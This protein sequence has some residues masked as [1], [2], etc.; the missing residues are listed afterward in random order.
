MVSSIA[1]G[2]ANVAV[3]VMAIGPPFSRTSECVE[4]TRAT[5]TVG[6]GAGPTSMVKVMDAELT[7]AAA[8]SATA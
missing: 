8:L 1:E 2:A 5:S 3:R 4:T 6:G 7:R